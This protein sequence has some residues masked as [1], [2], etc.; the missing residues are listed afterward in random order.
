M[1]IAAAHADNVPRNA[2]GVPVPTTN[3][4]LWPDLEFG[5]PGLQRSDGCD[6]VRVCG[7]DVEVERSEVVVGSERAQLVD[8]PLGGRE[9]VG[10]VGQLRKFHHILLALHGLVTRYVTGPLLA[11]VR[12]L[13]RKGRARQPA[14]P[15]GGLSG[16]RIDGGEQ[17]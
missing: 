2:M 4:G 15:L 13:Q 8:E 1:N 14:V 6:E 5:D 9:F 16:R 17:R 10:N 3:A 7:P 11:A 12:W